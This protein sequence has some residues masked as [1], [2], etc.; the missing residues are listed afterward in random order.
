MLADL[1]FWSICEAWPDSV[2]A[3]L[4]KQG[5]DRMKAIDYHIVERIGAE[6]QSDWADMTD[7][8]QP[9]VAGNVQ[10]ARDQL[11]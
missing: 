7:R 9:T 10:K 2:T 6:T 1:Q 8:A 3:D 5:L 11:D 4:R